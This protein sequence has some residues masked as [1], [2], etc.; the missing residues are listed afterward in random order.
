[1]TL[2]LS[3]RTARV[4][5]GVGRTLIGLGIITLLFVGYQLWGT[6]VQHSRAQDQMGDDFAARLEAT[7]S[8]RST[9]TTSTPQLPDERPSRGI[10]ASGP[11][12]LPGVATTTTTP[13]EPDEIDPEVLAALAPATGE[14]IAQMRIASIGVDET[15]VYGIGVGDLRKGP[16]VF[17]SNPLPG[18]PGNAAIAGHRTTYGAPFH[19]LDLILP[20]DE[21]V[22][23]TLRGE[24]TY[25]V[26]AHQNDEGI[27]VGHFI[28][29]ASGVHVLDDFGDNRIT[30]IA[31]H[32]KYSARQ[33]I[34][35]TGILQEEP[36][37]PPPTTVPDPD[38]PAPP[39]TTVPELP[40]D[41][42]GEG[43]DGDRDALVPTA[44]WAGLFALALLVTIVLGHLWR[45]WP[46]YLLSAPLLAW[47]LW[48][49]FVY[50][51]RLLPSY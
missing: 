26:E 35:V 41:E 32:P 28:V 33:R 29:P 50:L 44:I 43:L 15:V 48:S 21:I 47:L 12:E 42:W 36:V 37:E 27:E 22:V 38:D 5:G 39:P 18:T 20:G 30:L 2:R 31:C 40:D 3:H 11:L 19:N 51:D 4:V 24:F 17:P 9:T 1:M 7:E 46:V 8:A 25:V 13:P 14:P 6:G 45:R 10:G 16:G 49:C 23:E 34:I